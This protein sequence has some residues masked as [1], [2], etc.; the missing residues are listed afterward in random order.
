MA[1]GRRRRRHG[2]EDGDGRKPGRPRKPDD[3][4]ELV[5][6]LGKETGWGYARILGEVRKL[7]TVEVSRQFVVN[8]LKEAG[9]DPTPRKERSWGDFVKAHAATLWQADFFGTRV[10]TC[11]GWKD[12][13]VLAWI[14]V[15][16][17]KVF[18]SEATYHPDAVW[19]EDQG[20]AFVRHV[21]GGGPAW[22]LS[23]GTTTPSTRRRSTP[24]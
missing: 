13:F 2:Q 3:L 18:T 20:R 1:P 23:C 21:R 11:R 22:R 15:A 9:L 8:L 6:R 24:A 19:V 14:H 10:L 5:V 4:R 17:R 7:T 16:S 12:A